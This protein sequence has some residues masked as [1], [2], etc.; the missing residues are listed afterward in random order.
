MIHCIF[1]ET[2]RTGQINV[3]P[4][5]YDNLKVVTTFPIFTAISKSPFHHSESVDDQNLNQNCNQ[6][7]NQTNHDDQFDETLSTQISS[8]YDLYDALKEFSFKIPCN[9]NDV[10]SFDYHT[11]TKGALY[12]EITLCIKENVSITLQVL[13]IL[14][15]N[16][17]NE[18]I[19]MV[20][21]ST[22]TIG[23]RGSGSNL[24]TKGF[25]ENSLEGFETAYK[26]GA[27]F[28]EFDVQLTSENVPVIYHDF[29]IKSDKI[30]HIEPLKTEIDGSLKYAL[31]Q[32]STTEFE[33]AGLQ[34]Q[35]KQKY[36]TY[37]ELLQKLPNEMKFDVEL[38]YPFLEKFKDVPYAERNFF[39]DQTLEEMKK[40]AYNRK[41]FF[42]SFDV[43][44]VVMLSF[45][46]KRWPIFQLMSRERGETLDIFVQKTINV[47]PLLKELGIKGFV[48]N[49]KYLMMAQSMVKELKDMGFVIATYGVHNNSIDG[50]VS[51]LNL[52]VSGLCTDNMVQLKKTVSDYVASQ[53][54][55]LF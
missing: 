39:V 20:F 13:I 45:K 15:F 10:L 22:F 18:N 42:S 1:I 52:G 54:Q 11:D 44:S 19:D 9:D 17:L 24:V 21:P 55:E 49:S 41:L 2:K 3:T 23:H 31:R 26:S 33:N 14:P 32:L 12:S 6:N 27:D 30:N 48:F 5:Q 4:G 34:S 38:K 40:N 51:Q 53:E 35:W 25:L 43:L 8:S 47:A 46:Q 16:G 37:S 36:L 7:L 50:I 28:V 29:Y